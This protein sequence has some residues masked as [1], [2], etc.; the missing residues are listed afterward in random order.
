MTHA[1]CQSPSLDR[2]LCECDYLVFCTEVAPAICRIFVVDKSR[3]EKDSHTSTLC[4]EFDNTGLEALD[5]VN[6]VNSTSEAATYDDFVLNVLSGY[7]SDLNP[8]DP[9]TPCFAVELDRYRPI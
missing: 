9:K 5:A 8:Y 1:R 6:G 4:T 7:T 3:L 2:P